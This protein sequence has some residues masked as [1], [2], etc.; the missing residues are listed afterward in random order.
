MCNCIICICI[1]IVSSQGRLFDDYMGSNSVYASPNSFL[2]VNHKQLTPPLLS[3]LTYPNT[4]A[5]NYTLLSFT[6][7]QACIHLYTLLSFTC[8]HACTHLTQ[9]NRSC[10]WGVLDTMSLVS[11]KQNLA[12]SMAADILPK[13][14]CN[15][16]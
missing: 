1:Y 10:L 15:P 8:A 13:L 16:Q 9:T 14:S 11:A 12:C 4:Y 7:A 5:K 2:S 3:L 6:C